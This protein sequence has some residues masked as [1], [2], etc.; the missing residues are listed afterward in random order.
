MRYFRE[1]GCDWGTGG[2]VCEAAAFGGSLELLQWCVANGAIF[3]ARTCDEA[4]AAGGHLDV[5]IYAHSKDCKVDEKTA[6]AAAAH[7]HARCPAWILENQGGRF[8]HSQ[9]LVDV[10]RS[11]S[12]ACVKL[13][14]THGSE[15]DSEGEDP[16]ELVGIWS[17]WAG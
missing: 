10:Q 11:I 3:G 13:A 6:R 8:T 17:L 1:N 2:A 14:E 15:P 9:I 5:L 12:V 7:R 16:A 4:A